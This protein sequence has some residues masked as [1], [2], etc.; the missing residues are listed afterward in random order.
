MIDRRRRILPGQVHHC[1]TT[2]KVERVRW[3][4]DTAVRTFYCPTCK[5]RH[6]HEATDLKANLAVTIPRTG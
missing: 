5:T 1:G 4:G 3:S 6:H 2:S